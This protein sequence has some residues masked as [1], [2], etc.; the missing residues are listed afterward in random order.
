MRKILS[1]VLLTCTLALAAQ[2]LDVDKQL[3]YCHS[4]VMRAL[5]ELQGANG[6]DFSQ[7]PRNILSTDKLKGWNTRK[8]TAEEWCS[9]FWPG[10]LWMDYSHS[11]EAKVLQAAEGYTEALRP[12]AYQKAF[13]HDLGFLMFCSFGKGYE[14][15]RRDD[16][17]QVILAAADTLATLFN[18]MV[19]TLL[20]WPRNI[21]MFSGHNT[22]MDNMMNLDML[23]WA[24]QHG[25][26]PLLHPMAV[27]HARTTMEHHFRPDGTCYHVAVYDTLSGRFLRGVTHQ[28]YADSS[29]WTRGQSWAIY[30][31]TM[32][33]R[34]TQSPVFLQFA[35][36]VTDIYI[37]RLKQAGGD[38]IPKWDFDDPDAN[39]PKDVSAAC[40]VADALLELSQYCEGEKGNDYRQFA[41]ESLAQLSTPA[42]QSGERNVAFLMHSTGHHPAGSE[43]DASI[44]YA[45]YYYLEALLRVKYGLPWTHSK[46]TE[47]QVTLTITNPSPFQR[48][49]V[50]EADAQAVLDS[51]GAWADS[52]LV[53]M[54]QAGQELTYQI[55]HDRKLL[56]DAAV[57]PK[58]SWTIQV[59]R[60]TPC[61]GKK[62]VQGALYKQRKDDIA[63]ENDRCAYRVYGPALQ[64]SGEKAYGIDVWVKNTPDPVVAQRYAKDKQSAKEAEAQRKAGQTEAAQLTLLHGS[65]HLDQGDGM[66]GYGVGP[67]LGCGAPALINGQELIYPY[68]YTQYEILDN[69]PLR[70][71]VKLHY[72]TNTLGI[73]EHRIISLD[74]GSHF[75][76]I[77][78]WYDG[79]TKP[80]TFCAGVTLNGKG[81][82][83]RDKRFIAYEDPTDRPEV[84]GSSIYTAVCFPF[85][86]VAT[87]LS[88]DKRNAVGT[89]KGYRGE[90][91]T[92]YAGAAWSRY[93]MADFTLWKHTI[94]REMEAVEQPLA[95]HIS[96]TN[97]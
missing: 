57:P 7:Q 30:G 77:K 27:T 19:G 31:F 89:I 91:V 8:A 34:Y 35:Q 33:Y 49:E 18:P 20:S 62:L 61:Q 44:I 64:Q 16:Y 6:Y 63:W 94:K 36:H 56:I 40:I 45:D 28:G 1:S 42:Y 81:T 78:V 96:T 72:G 50:V 87:G 25:G 10:I 14:V 71:T 22:I 51:L 9:G 75:N 21:G 86:A 90:E 60:G 38:L 82:L 73:T 12:L 88:P 47:Q 26:T 52:S 69:G 4:Q 80:F 68:C 54:N 65:F 5:A 83:H 23:C 43:I 76:K 41:L 58:G 15:D 55:T 13:D 48:Q 24:A 97:P 3:H 29:T 85:H 53:L 59:L 11:R 2:E 70:F 92:Y 95:V 84:H 32:M 39:A 37:Q 74:K 67:T 46:H 79:V 66:D 93:D 17:R